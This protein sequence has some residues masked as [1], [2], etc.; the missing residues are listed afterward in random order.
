MARFKTVPKE[1][2]SG[3]PKKYVSRQQE[4]GSDQGRD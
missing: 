4:Q 2:E 1:K 3:L